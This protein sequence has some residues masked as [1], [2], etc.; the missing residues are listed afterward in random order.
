MVSIDWMA[1]AKISSLHQPTD[2]LIRYAFSCSG[3]GSIAQIYSLSLLTVLLS[4][5]HRPSVTASIGSS[6]SSKLHFLAISVDVSVGNGESC[7][8]VEPVNFL[9]GSAIQ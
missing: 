4:R 9:D 1:V 2:E 6:W 5:S 8:F 3:K 7:S